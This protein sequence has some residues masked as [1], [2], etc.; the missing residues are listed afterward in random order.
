MKRYLVQAHISKILLREAGRV[1]PEV[2]FD[3]LAYNLLVD[4]SGRY[5]W[6]IQG[7]GKAPVPTELRKYDKRRYSATTGERLSDAT[8]F[9]RWSPSAETEDLQ[10]KILTAKP[11]VIAGAVATGAAILGGLVFLFKGKSG[12]LPDGSYPPPG[13]NAGAPL[14]DRRTRA[15]G[16]VAGVVPSKYGDA[17]FTQLAPSYKADDPKLPAG[18]TTCGYLVCYVAA[19][20]GLQGMI[21][22]C[23]TNGVRDAGKTAGAWV[24]AGGAARPLPSDFYCIVNDKGGVD[25]VGV[26]VDASGPVWKTAD[27]GQG[28]RGEGQ[29]ALYV[30]RPY[31]ANAVTLEGRKLG[32]WCNLDKM[33]PLAA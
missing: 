8:L 25:H 5:V 7:H 28:T 26:I 2:S 14:S 11:L 9:S 18:F 27:A 24:D 3:N 23:G 31:D 12:A 20:L 21:T 1:A 6:E 33:T 16:L 15:L 29:E 30:D 10:K 17:K 13:D 19:K 22:R 32:G 4:P